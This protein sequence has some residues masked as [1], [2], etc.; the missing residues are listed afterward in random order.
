MTNDRGQYSHHRDT[1]QGTKLIAIFVDETSKNRNLPGYVGPLCRGEK[2]LSVLVDV[3]ERG[4]V[5]L[6]DTKEFKV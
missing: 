1:A 4:A 6:K 3:P 5:V 2:I